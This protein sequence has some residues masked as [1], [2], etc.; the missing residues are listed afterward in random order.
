[1]EVRPSF[2]TSFFT[3]VI[4][5]GT[6]RAVLTA[7]GTR[8]LLHDF[9]VPITF[10]RSKDVF[11]RTGFDWGCRFLVKL[12]QFLSVNDRVSEFLGRELAEL[13]RERFG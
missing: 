8:K 5:V 11:P 1:V 13:R 6:V 7:V 3:D 2:R 4:E 10:G 9:G 12:E